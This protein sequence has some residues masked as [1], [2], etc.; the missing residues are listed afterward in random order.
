MAAG[1]LTLAQELEIRPIGVH[2]LQ[3]IPTLV[4]DHDLRAIGGVVDVDD[5]LERVLEHPQPGPGPWLR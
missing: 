5:V 2:D 3:A 4:E 1:V